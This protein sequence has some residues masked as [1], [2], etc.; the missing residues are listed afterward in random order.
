MAYFLRK[1]L[2][3]ERNYKIYDMELLAIIEAFREW[4]AYLEGFKHIIDI[5]SDHLN[6]TY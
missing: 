5:Y 3:L 6:L 1:I 2:R 4:E